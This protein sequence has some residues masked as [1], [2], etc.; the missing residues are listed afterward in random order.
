M[1]VSMTGYGYGEAQ[2]PEIKL[3]VELKSV[4]NRFCDV[5]VRIPREYMALEPRIVALVREQYSRGRVDLFIRKL[6][7]VPSEPRVQF[8][9]A[10]ASQYHRQLEAL[11]GHLNLPG[12]INLTMLLGL[13]GVAATLE[14]FRD[15]E[16]DWPLVRDAVSQALESVRQMRRQ[17]GEALR[18]DLAARIALLRDLHREMTELS[19]FTQQQSQDRL[20]QKVI[21]ALGRANAGDI[22]AGRLLQEVVYLVD[23]VDITE[24][25]TRFNSHLIQLSGLLDETQPVGRKVDFLLQELLREANTIGSKTATPDIT[26]CGMTIKVELEKI[27]EQIQNVE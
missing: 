13:D 12:E 26:R 8:N 15:P 9:M 5:Q 16:V 24:E 27:R 6:D 18:Q 25:L 23:R 3:Q 21:E 4:N 20:H 14:V 17:E 7:L 2:S 19:H 11:K 10:L 22:D 1:L